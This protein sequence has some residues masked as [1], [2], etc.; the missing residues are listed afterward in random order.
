MF[1]GIIEELGTVRSISKNGDSARISIL[2]KKVTDSKL[3]DSISVNGV[4]LTVV[5]IDSA[6]F[7]ADISFE[8]LKRSGLN[9]LK[10]GDNVNIERAITLTTRLGGHLVLGHIDCVGEIVSIFKK[11]TAHEV[12]VKYDVKI[13]KFIAEKGSVALDGI[14]LTISSVKNCVLT[15]AVIPHTF[16]NTNLKY[17][18]VGDMLNIE[19]DIIS[20]YIDK[21]L[22]NQE[23]DSRLSQNRKDINLEKNIMDMY[24]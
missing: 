24:F 13:D 18:K 21:L 19:V 3:G 8:S 2:A 5:N 4:C 1:T 15:V 12:K 7:E 10:L 23:K 17:K 16:E 9:C 14:S 6:G 22:K 20:R 11:A